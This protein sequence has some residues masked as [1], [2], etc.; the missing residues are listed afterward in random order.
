MN[1]RQK[2]FCQYYVGECQGNVTQAGL[3]AGYSESYATHKLYQ[4]LKKVDIQQY[5]QQLQVDDEA[6]RISTGD[7]IRCFWSNIMNNKA[8]PIKDRIKASELLAKCK[9]LFKD[10]W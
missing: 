3:K 4:I 6:K 5:I 8:L 1:E 2:L 10:E 9:G 7:D